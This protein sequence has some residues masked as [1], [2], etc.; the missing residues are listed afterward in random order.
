M[1]RKKK[2]ENPLKKGRTKRGCV[3]GSRMTEAKETCGDKGKDRSPGGR[4][5]KQE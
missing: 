2:M 3:N 5:N 1:A 4:H